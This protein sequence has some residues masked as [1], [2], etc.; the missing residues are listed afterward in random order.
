MPHEKH[1]GNR[2]VGT[3]RFVTTELKHADGGT[4]DLYGPDPNGIII[5]TSDGYFAL[6]NTRP[7]RLRFASNNSMEGT[8]DENRATVHGSVA[9]FGTYSVDEANSSFSIYI[10][11]SSFP[12][13][14]R[15]TQVRPFTIVADQLKFI[16]PVST[17]GGLGVCATL[18]RARPP[19]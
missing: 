5:F 2:L 6:T 3:W 19:F 14:E 7:G 9:Y 15:T 10:E 16:N 12:N 1:P 4:V 17:V 8:A 13:Y 11:G 18:R